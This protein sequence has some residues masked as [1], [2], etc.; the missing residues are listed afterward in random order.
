MID[1]IAPPWAR[2]LGFAALLVTG[3]PAFAQTNAQ[4]PAAPAPSAWSFSLGAGAIFA[5]KYEGSDRLAVGGLP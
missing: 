3:L 2:G 5:P 4:P 1:R